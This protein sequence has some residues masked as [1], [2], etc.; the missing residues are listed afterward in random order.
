MAR[1]V[2]VVSIG[3]RPPR[4][5][6]DM[7]S[8]EIVDYM[9]DH[10]A[11]ELDQ[12]LIDMPDLIVVPEACDR[13]APDDF[14]LGRRLAYYRERKDRVRDF[15]AKTAKENTCYIV[16]SAAREMEDGSWRNSSVLLDRTGEV[17]GVY[18]KNH[19]VMEEE[20]EKAGIRCGRSAPV[21]TCDFG[22]VACL[23]CFDL[24]F[25]ELRL[26]YIE[27]RP[28]LLLFSSVYHG[29][30]LVQGYWA[31]SCR[32]YFVGA[33]AGLP[34]EIRN[35]Y[36]EVVGAGTNYRDY[37]FASINLDFCLVHY[38][39]NREKLYELKRQYGRDVDIH[40]PGYFGSVM[41]SSVSDGKSARE[42]I[43]EFEIEP[44]DAY[45]AGESEL[46]RRDKETRR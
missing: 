30:D 19:L 9:I 11:G 36:G 2:R 14:P 3:P 45:L 35:P 29:G 21:F 10:W 39:F 18:D 43:E 20:N 31:Y 6:P 41:V 1:H 13:P 34:C 26:K 8:P 12:V 44:L 46:Q 24:N 23:I 16:Y 4:V 38:D 15:F 7:E 33:V 42:M 17:V 27:A 37:A 5:A 40:D 22:R 25:D 28:D 32:S